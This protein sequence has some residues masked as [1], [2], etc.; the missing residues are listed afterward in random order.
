MERCEYETKSRCREAGAIILKIGYGYT[1]EPHKSDP[2][3]DSVDKA[4][5]QFSAATVPGAWMVDTIPACKAFSPWQRVRDDI[6]DYPVRYVP[7]WIPGAGFKKTAKEW[8]A[9]LMEVA[10][11]PLQFVK[12]EMAAKRNEPSFV[13]N[14]YDKW[15]KK[16]SAEEEYVTKWSAASLYTGG[17][18]TVSYE[19]CFSGHMANTC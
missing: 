6:D 9:T 1:V 14:I 8:Y 10:E 18:D 19:Y 4:L 12:Q 3:V 16:M 7:E 17:A 5:A 11:R 2:L 13:S 15:E